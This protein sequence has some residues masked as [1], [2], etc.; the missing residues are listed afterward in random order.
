MRPWAI[1]TLVGLLVGLLA[2][3]IAWAGGALLGW[4]GSPEVAA[5][6]G[7]ITIIPALLSLRGGAVARAAGGALV[8]AVSLSAAVA[9]AAA[10]YVVVLLV[11]GRAPSDDDQRV[12][13]AALLAVIIAVIA[14][15]LIEPALRRAT[16]GFVVRE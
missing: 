8:L 9:V 13:A 1:W 5:S 6:L 11:L 2:A 15:R 3:T 4:T 16:R 12:I 7:L 10:A 14:Y